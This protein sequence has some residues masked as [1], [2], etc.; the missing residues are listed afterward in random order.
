MSKLTE[1][2][3]A[4]YSSEIN[5]GLS[6]FWD[7]GFKVWL[8][9]ETNGIKEYSNGYYPEEFDEAAQWLHDAAVKHYPHSAYTALNKD[10]HPARDSDNVS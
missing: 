1:V 5:C 3:K 9:D 6:S 8:G 10:E 7:G 2:M 4:L